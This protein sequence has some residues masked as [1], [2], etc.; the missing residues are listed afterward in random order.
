MFGTRVGINQ[1]LEAFYMYNS[2]RSEFKKAKLNYEMSYKTLKRAEL[3]LNYNVSSLF[4]GLLSAKERKEIALQTLKRQEDAFEIAKSKFDAGLIREVESL[5]MEVD[6]NAAQ[7]DF[8][9]ASVNYLSQ[10]NIFKQQ[11]GIP[12]LDSV[13]VNSDFSYTI[14]D[15]NEEKAVQLG[16]ENRLEVRE[17][18]IQVELSDI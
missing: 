9:I 15:I 7:N 12:L 8:D 13:E 1:P 17:K 4:Y 18:Q 16:L 10:A 14:V 11:I 3:D 2:I 6:L 5:Q